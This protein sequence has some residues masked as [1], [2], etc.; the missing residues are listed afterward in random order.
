MANLTEEKRQHVLALG[1]LRW[2]LRRI[3]EATGARRETASHYLKAAGLQGQGRGRSPV[4]PA[5]PAISPEASTD[6]SPATAAGKGTEQEPVPPAGLHEV[7]DNADRQT[8]WPCGAPSR[9][10]TGQTTT[11]ATER[12]THREEQPRSRFPSARTTSAGCE[13]L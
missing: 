1:R 6:S 7:E 2:S 8:T 9:T 13:Q 11:G 10:L 4:R 12:L 5:E 3:E